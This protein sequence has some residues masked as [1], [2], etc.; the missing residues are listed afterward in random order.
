MR[1][2][3]LTLGFLMF[4]QIGVAETFVSFPDDFQFGLANAPAHVEDQLQDS[5]L[6]FA[7]NGH[8]AAYKNYFKPEERLQFWSQPEIEIDLAASSGV[9]IFR[10][11]I[12]WGR[13]VPAM[14]L[15]DSEE[16]FN[17][18]KDDAALDRYEEI[19]DYV[20]SKGMT[21]WVTLFHHSYPKW[22]IA[23]GGW[24]HPSSKIQ[25]EHFSSL[26]FNKLKIKLTTGS[27]LMSLLFMLAYL[28]CMVHGLLVLKDLTF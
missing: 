24:T 3:L 22:G 17:D 21:P 16:C 1:V 9:K 19:I 7:E 6:E 2:I 20:I 15:C 14:P 11:G 23:G 8:V 18:T 27:F 4:S 26:I 5:W 13:V 12:D 28:T 25:F 10:M